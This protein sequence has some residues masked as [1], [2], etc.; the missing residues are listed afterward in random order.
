MT[1]AISHAGP[2]QAESIIRRLK[3]DLDECGEHSGFYWNR[4]MIRR[5][6]RDGE[7][8]CMR[9]G[10]RIIGFAVHGALQQL[11]RASIDLLEVR[12]AHRGLGHGRQLAEHVIAHLFDAGAESI[13]VTCSPRSSRGFWAT[14][15]FVA[16]PVAPPTDIVKMTLHRQLE[17]MKHSN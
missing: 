7:L 17:A 4:D 8:I 15:G 12:Q 2:V 11:R 13:R 3:H 5:A 10:R 14:L 6:A 16:N 9:L 1:V